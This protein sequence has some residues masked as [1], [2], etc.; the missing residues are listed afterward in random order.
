MP[1]TG[2][3]DTLSTVRMHWRPDDQITIRLAVQRSGTVID[4]A[5]WQQGL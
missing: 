4:E 3:T 2:A 5:R 1:T